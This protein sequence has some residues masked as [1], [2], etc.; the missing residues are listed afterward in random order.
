MRLL[1]YSIVNILGTLTKTV[2]HSEVIC[3]REVYTTPHGIYIWTL[4]NYIF[5]YHLPTFPPIWFCVF[6]F[7]YL[8]PENNHPCLHLTLYHPFISL[9]LHLSLEK[10]LGSIST[11]EP[12]PPVT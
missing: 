11:F 6:L 2:T 1:I 5:N 12:S 4:S 10:R 3:N 9:L 8:L 7:S